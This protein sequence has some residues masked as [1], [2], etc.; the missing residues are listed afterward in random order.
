MTTSK[1]IERHAGFAIKQ[2]EDGYFWENGCHGDGGFDTVQ[3]CRADIDRFNQE[4]A[5]HYAD[6]D[7]PPDTP[8]LPAPWWSHV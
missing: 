8:C 6:I 7:T 3:E 1:T 4:E 2:D 5:E